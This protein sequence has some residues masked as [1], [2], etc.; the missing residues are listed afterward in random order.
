LNDVGEPFDVAVVGGGPGGAA[1]A[2]CLARLGWRVAVLEATS[3]EGE[4]LGETLPPEINAV[5]RDLALCHAFESVEPVESP[6][7]VSAWG[8]SEPSHVDF[9]NNPYGPGWHIDRN[10]FDAMLCTEAVAAG[11]ELFSR[12]PIR[13]CVR[14]ENGWRLGEISTRMLVDASGRN[15]LTTGNSRQIEVDDRLLAI[16]LRISSSTK[17]QPDFRTYIEATPAGWWYTAPLPERQMVAMF[18]TDCQNYARGT[19]RLEDQ[20]REAPA[21]RSRLRH[22]TVSSRRT[23]YVPS[24]CSR[25]IVGQDLMLIGDS[26]SCYDPLSGRG[27]FKALRHAPAAAAAMDGLLRGREEPGAAYSDRVIDEFR[28]YA[29]Q[30]RSYYAGESRWSNYP[31]WRA[32]RVPSLGIAI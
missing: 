8:G 11:A 7:I 30:R 20:L 19:L 21:T 13:N 15:G 28:A 24:F 2:L 1:T 31:F 5:L 32:R 23:V 10:R 9:V 22:S 16:V 6:G 27:I 17:T 4:R 14:E 26:A 3:F 25:R 18:F 12:C 29:R